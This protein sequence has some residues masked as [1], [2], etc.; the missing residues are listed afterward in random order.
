LELVRVKFGRLVNSIFMIIDPHDYPANKLAGYLQSAVVPRPIAFVSTVDSQGT[1]N[2]SPFSFFNVFSIQP[3]ILIFSPSRRVRDN[4][5]KHTLENVLQVQEAVISLVNYAM[6][7][8][9]SLASVE[10]PKGVNEFVKAGFTP[11]PSQRVKPPRVKESPVAFECHVKQVIHLGEQGG[12][13]NLVICEIILMHIQDEV[14]NEAEVIDPYKL[15]AVARMGGDYYCRATQESIFT[16]PKPSQSI[17][18]G[19]DQLPKA[20][21]ESE[22]LTGNDLGRLASVLVIPN[23]KGTEPLLERKEAHTVAKKLLA[24]DKIEEAWR[25]LQASQ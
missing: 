15:D 19:F 4:S 23:F 25:I 2:L 21:R 13:G 24:E 1:V 11:M 18:I 20:I 8:Q 3:P 10:F 17:S 14:L 6:V 7:E 22:I 12:A 16:I 9:T 5:I